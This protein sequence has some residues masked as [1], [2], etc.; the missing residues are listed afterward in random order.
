MATATTP[1][2]LKNIILKRLGA[3]VNTINVTDDQLYEAIDRAVDIYVDYHYDGV[4]KMY[5]VHTLTADEVQSGLIKTGV[6]LQA[7]SRVYRS[8]MSVGVGWYDGAVF[9]AGWQ[10]GADLL[11]NLSGSM[12]G[13]SSKS[14][15]GLFGGGGYAL[16]TFDAFYQYLELLQRFFS[17]EFNFWFNTDS[18]TLRILNDG[19]LY[20]GQVVLIECYVRA[21]VY[22][23][24]S[25]VQQPDPISGEY[26]TSA[27]Q[28]YHD[29]YTY[30][31]TGTSPTDP[32]VVYMDQSIYN[33]RWLKEMATAYT[34]L[35]WGQN[36]KKFQGMPLP[37]G[38]TV[39]GQQ[40]YDEANAEIETLRK[41]LLLIQ[42]PLPFYM[43]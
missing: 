28:N 43:E 9:D 32:G 20:E 25:Y 11:K 8:T 4:N 30:T 10:A 1:T 42:E 22:V 36:L 17:P 33:N 38:I 35:Q 29:P 18:S 34:K 6:Q 24:Q 40:I 14:G 41:E 3:P 5:L 31:I 26:V 16:A 39:N 19:N 2:Q 21:G 27:R 37:G 23:D 15:S 7:V 13:C 12:A